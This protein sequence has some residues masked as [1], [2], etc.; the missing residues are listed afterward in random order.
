MVLLSSCLLA[1]LMSEP[2]L[3]VELVEELTEDDAEV[4]ERDMVELAKKDS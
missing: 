2:K 4:P 3:E 1:L